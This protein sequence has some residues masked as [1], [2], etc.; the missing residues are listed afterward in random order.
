MWL[1]R[2]FDMRESPFT[3]RGS[4]GPKIKG[5]GLAER[6]G[7][8]MGTGDRAIAALDLRR[9]GDPLALK[10]R[11]HAMIREIKALPRVPRVDEILIPGEPE[12]RYRRQQLQDGLLLTPEAV[13]VLRRNGSQILTKRL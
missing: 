6:K 1:I 11:M 4:E 3:L 2:S 10:M 12:A 5:A 9:F 13:E 8:G 7:V